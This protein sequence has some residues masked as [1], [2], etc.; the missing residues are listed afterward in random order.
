MRKKLKWTLLTLL[1]LVVLAVG[2]GAVWAYNGYNKLDSLQKDEGESRFDQFDEKP[3]VAPPEWTGTERVNILLMGGDDRGLREGEVA[4]SDSMMVASFDPVTKKAHLFS[5]L[6]DTYAEIPGYKDNRINTAITLGGPNLAMKTIGDLT[7]LNIQYYVYADFQGFIKLVDAIGGVDFYVEKDMHYTDAADGHVYDIDLKEGQQH[8]D[9]EHAL[10]YVRFRH[11]AMS[12]F[13]RTERQREFLKA[14]ANK[15]KSGWNLVKLPDI[16]GEVSPF[17]ETN[18]SAN[19]MLKLA[20]LGFKSHQAG[21]A[22]LPPME[23]ISDEKVGGASVLGI[24]DKDELKEY[25]QEVLNKDD[26]AAATPSPSAS[27][28]ASASGSNSDSSDS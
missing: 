19:D 10:Q 4:R 8:L 17:I 14:V 2:A 6:R 18:L 24:T 23:L 26:T 22:Q 25:V 20:S 5:I 28:S 1:A 21:S 7:G 9:G 3:E 12:D 11:D 15:L 13:T 27:G 16:I